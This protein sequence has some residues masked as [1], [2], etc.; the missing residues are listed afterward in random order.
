[1]YV[2][3]KATQHLG[4]RLSTRLRAGTAVKNY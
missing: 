2:S 3:T 1:M 4:E